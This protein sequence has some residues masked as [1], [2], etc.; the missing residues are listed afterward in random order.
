MEAWMDD[1]ATS[2]DDFDEHLANV[3]RILE[4]CREHKL[5]LNPAKCQLFAS[6]LVWCG[7]HVSKDGV[8]PDKAKVQTVVEWPTPQNPHE[9]LRCINFAGHYRKLIKNF[10]QR[11]APLQA[12]AVL[13]APDWSLPFIIETDASIHGLGAVLSQKFRYEH[14]ETGQIID[15]IHPI[16]YAS[17]GTKPSEKRYSAFLLELVGVKWA[18]EKFKPYVFGRPIELISDCQALA[19][20]LSLQSVSPAHSRWREY[21]LGHDI[22]KFT[23][24]AG[25]LNAAADE[26]SRRKDL[27]A[28]EEV[29]PDAT[30]PPSWQE[31]KEEAAAKARVQPEKANP[32]GLEHLEPIFAAFFLETHDKEAAL[33][34][35]FADDPFFAPIIEFLLTLQP[36]K[37]A[38]PPEAGLLRRQVRSYFIAPDGSLRRVTNHDHAGRECIPQRERRALTLAAHEQLAHAGRDRIIAH[39]FPRFYWPNMTASVGATIAA[40]MQCQQF[41]RQ[42]FRSKLQPITS[43]AP[44][45]LLSMDYFSL[46]LTSGFKSVLVVVDYFSRF[47]WA[48]KFKRDTGASTITALED[49]FARFGAPAV[50]LSDNGSHLNSKEVNAFCE[51]YGVDRRTTPTYSPHTNGLVE[52]TNATLLRALERECAP[53]DPD[54]TPT[55][56]P[57]VLQR[58]VDRLNNRVVSTTG[59]RPSELIFGYDRFPRIAA[60][61][62]DEV[63]SA[64]LDTMLDRRVDAILVTAQAESRADNA[65]ITLM[66]N[67]GARKERADA[68]HAA[69]LRGTPVTAHSTLKRGDIVWLHE[70][71]LTMRLNHKLQRE[72]AGPY[73]I[74][75][76]ASDVRPDTTVDDPHATNV[77]FWLDDPFSGRQL[78]TRVHANRLKLAVFPDDEPF[79]APTPLPSIEDYFAAW[80]DPI[81]QEQGD[82]EPDDD[83]AVAAPL[84]EARDPAQDDPPDTMSG[85]TKAQAERFERTVFPPA[86]LGIDTKGTWFTSTLIRTSAFHAPNGVPLGLTAAERKECSPAV[87]LGIDTST[88]SPHLA[89]RIEKMVE[90]LGGSVTH[91]VD[92]CTAGDSALNVAFTCE[93]YLSFGNHWTQVRSESDGLKFVHQEALWRGIGQGPTPK[94]AAGAA[95]ADMIESGLIPAILNTALEDPLIQGSHLWWARVLVELDWTTLTYEDRSAI[96]TAGD[97]HPD[98]TKDLCGG[99]SPSY[100]P[101]NPGGLELLIAGAADVRDHCASVED[102]DYRAFV[103]SRYAAKLHLTGLNSVGAA[104]TIINIANELTGDLPEKLSPELTQRARDA[105]ALA[106][107]IAV[108]ARDAL[109]KERDALTRTVDGIAGALEN[110][111]RLCNAIQAWQ[112]FQHD[113]AAHHAALNAWVAQHG[114]IG[115]WHAAPPTQRAAPPPPPAPQNVD[116]PVFD[117]STLDEVYV[118]YLA[119]YL[120]A[121]D[122]NAPIDAARASSV[123]Q[124]YP[125]KALHAE[126]SRLID[127]ADRVAQPTFPNIAG[128]R[129]R[130]LKEQ[131]T[132]RPTLFLL[133][134]PRQ[135]DG[136]FRPEGVWEYQGRPFHIGCYVPMWIHGGGPSAQTLLTLRDEI[137]DWARLWSPYLRADYARGAKA[138][139]T[140][141]EHGGSRLD[142]Q[143]KLKDAH[144]HQQTLEREYIETYGHELGFHTHATFAAMSTSPTQGQPTA[145]PP[146]SGSLSTGPS[147]SMH[148]SQAYNPYGYSA[149]QYDQPYDSYRAPRGRGRGRGRGRR[150][151]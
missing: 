80:E 84:S 49:I 97:A 42:V 63:L 36:P 76:R 145:Y 27:N 81:E 62:T 12:L 70:S 32:T 10:A 120:R 132:D 94:A 95:M 18:L 105:D 22:V 19:G 124:A 82:Q 88:A 75:A 117:P 77:T 102:R 141:R 114:P 91:R 135:L 24:R 79:T 55:K 89:D 41:G 52:R 122:F 128:I 34:Q 134:Q 48:Y 127:F 15:S 109:R 78:A 23:H 87:R 2:A 116:A 104:S 111:T 107:E 67:Q 54:S 20:I 73:R 140:I 144:K 113:S 133:D 16:K 9:V 43:L 13:R 123:D 143:T 56:W 50:L 40:C 139:E 30:I 147:R 151:W 37:N 44:M 65:L 92:A 51:D 35:R 108:A 6:S 112:Q 3:R 61:S 68:R 53:A 66:R 101:G 86:Q 72:W 119:E 11:T 26:L 118:P 1:L 125:Y 60:S 25:R 90:P 21:I 74:V 103:Q 69:A 138:R 28:G 71:H 130:R 148:Q 93:S 17:K 85:R 38:T 96:V 59:C 126:L 131:L 33:R 83:D 115:A 58:I 150:M 121:G 146:P 110:G 4:V 31:Y 64:A 142:V 39:L 8:Q 29:S 47:T 100:G 99:L 46:P 106:V 57:T 98:R 45:Q 136:P 129:G 137:N 7:S 14:P 5:S 149:P